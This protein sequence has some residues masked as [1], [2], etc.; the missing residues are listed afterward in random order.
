VTRVVA[1]NEAGA[2]SSSEYA[3][4]GHER[5][6]LPPHTLGLLGTTFNLARTIAG[7]EGT[8]KIR[9]HHL[10]DANQYRLRRQI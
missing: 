1:I 3:A 2:I 8:L 10:P 4:T 6:R 5:P 9:T 7:L